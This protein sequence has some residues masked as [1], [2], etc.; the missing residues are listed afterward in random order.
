MKSAIR[1]AKD[2]G[3]KVAIICDLHGL[4]LEQAKARVKA[5][6]DTCISEKVEG[7]KIITGKDGHG[8]EPV[9]MTQIPKYVELNVT[10]GQTMTLGSIDKE[11]LSKFGKNEVSLAESALKQVAL[12][13]KY[14]V[15]VTTIHSGKNKANFE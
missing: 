5:A 2:S 13:E 8:N 15:K 1:S 6:I 12:L 7:L 14:G 9:L 10:E 11:F 4:T 3:R